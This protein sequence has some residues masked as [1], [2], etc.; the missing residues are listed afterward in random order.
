MFPIKSSQSYI[1]VAK[2]LNDAPQQ[3]LEF[4]TS[5]IPNGTP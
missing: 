2:V 4:V 1:N 3:S 5:I